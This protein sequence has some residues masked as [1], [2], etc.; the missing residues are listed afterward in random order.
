MILTKSEMKIG[1]QHHGQKMSLK[2]FE[3]AKVKP[4]YFCELARGYIVV[5][6]IANFPHMRRVNLIRRR[7]DHY[8]EENPGR[9]YEICGSME[10]KI[11][12]PKFDSER[13][14]D[15]AVYLTAPKKPH[16]RP[17]WRRWFPDLAIEVVSESSRDR[18][19]TQKREEYWDAGIK[20]YWIVDAKLEQVLILKR[21]RSK[22][23]E[24]ALG[25]A[26][27]C[28]TKLL[29]GFRLSCRAIFE[30]GGPERD[31]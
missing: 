15:I 1:P 9:V 20:E 21:G 11:Y 12:I 27:A 17:M 26:D 22:W 13:H 18:D 24:A 25:P 14:P 2:D 16:D 5:S 29:P 8:S 7:L 3:F 30:A 10:C 28:E 31:E 23:K 19:Y 4:G 6:E